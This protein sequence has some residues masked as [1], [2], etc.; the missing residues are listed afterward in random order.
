MSGLGI[1]ENQIGEDR[2]EFSFP[3]GDVKQPIYGYK[4]ELPMSESFDE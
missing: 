4:D 2:T 3:D 1:Q